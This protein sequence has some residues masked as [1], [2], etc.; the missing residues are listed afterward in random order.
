M[1]ILDVMRT[2]TPEEIAKML[3]HR[4]ATC[5]ICFA[6]TCAITTMTRTG[7]ATTVGTTG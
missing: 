2:G 1:T 6:A 4:S 5:R 7:N 3:A